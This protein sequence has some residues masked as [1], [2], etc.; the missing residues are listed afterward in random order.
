ME[1]SGM[2][3]RAAAVKPKPAQIAD[4]KPHPALVQSNSRKSRRKRILY[5]NC[6]APKSDTQFLSR[7]LPFC[8]N[9][10]VQECG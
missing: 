7:Q 10:W 2:G 1:R 5:Q 8:P 4:Q 9:H 3:L 6:K